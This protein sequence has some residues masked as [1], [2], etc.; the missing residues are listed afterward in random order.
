LLWLVWRWD[1]TNYL[2]GLPQTAI[3]PISASQVARI[4]GISH[5]HLAVVIFFWRQNVAQTDLEFV[6]FLS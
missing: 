6:I 4:I 2:P 3:L 1:L 5:Q